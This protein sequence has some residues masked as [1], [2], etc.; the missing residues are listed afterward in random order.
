M[1]LH[2]VAAA[3]QHIIAPLA[4]D[5]KIVGDQPMPALNEIEHALRFSDPAFA[6]EE[7]PDTEHVRQRAVQ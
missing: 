5:H 3:D 6:G 1:P 2:L 7:Q 4:R